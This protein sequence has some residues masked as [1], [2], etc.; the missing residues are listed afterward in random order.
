MDQQMALTW[1]LLFM[2]LLAL[3]WKPGAT[4][5][6]DTIPLQTLS[7]YNDYS[8]H[9]ICS[10]ADLEDAQDLINMTLYRKLG[11][12]YP[13]SCSLS[14]DL[15]WSECPSAH[16]C[17]PRRCVIA[18]TGFSITDEDYYSFQP[19]QDVG[20]Q[21][22][23]PLAQHVQPPPPKDI[24]ISPSGD[25]FLL[26]WNWTLGDAQV[27]WLSQEDVEFE[28]AYKRLQDTWEDALRLNTSDLWV[29]LASKLFLPSNIYVARVRTQLSPG[30]SWSGRPSRWSPEVQWNAQP[31]DKAQPQNLQ[32]FFDGIQSLSCSW[33]VWNQVVGSVSFGLFY[34]PSPAAPEK[35]CSP[36]VKEL[37]G[38]FCTRYYC[39]L[40]VPNPRAHSQYTVSVKLRKQG[41][42]IKSS[43][44]IQMHPPSLKVTKNGDSYNLRWETKKLLYSHIQHKFQV[45]YKK[46]LDSWEDSKTEILD[47]AHSMSLPRL[48]P[49]TS[50]SARVRVKPLPEY[51][52]IWSEW[53][54]E[55]T[56]TTNW[57][58]PTWGIVLI[59][60][61]LILILILALRFGCAYGCRLYRK[62]KEKIPNPSKSLLFQDGGKG[63]WSPSSTAAFATKNLTPR[64]PQRNFF[65]E[66]QGMSYSH[67]VDNEVSPLTIEVPKIV[68]DLPSGPDPT[69]VTSSEP[70]EQLSDGQRDPQTHFGKPESQKPNFD[71]N[72]P[73]LGPPKTHSLTNL[74]GQLVPPE[75]S[76]SLKP[77]L[78]HSLEYLCLPP[79]GQVQL[80]PLSQAMSK[81][82]AMDAERESSLKTTE[83]PSVEQRDSPSLD[84]RVE[85]QEPKD[86]AVTLSLNSG[87][88]ED[89]VVASG[90][91]TP[92]DLVLT[93]PTGPPSTSLG[94]SLGLPS[95]Q[96]PSL[97]LTLPGVPPGSPALPAPELDDYVELPPSISQPPKIPLG[98]PVPPV[99]S[100]TAVNPGE[101]REEVAPTSPHHEGLLVLQQVGDYCFLPGLAPGSLSPHSKPPSP[102]L[103]LEMVDLDQ[104]LSV[105]KPSCQPMPQVPAIQFF[106]SLKHQDYLSLPPWDSSQPGKVC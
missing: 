64:G 6:Q 97:C 51:Y 55:C 5:A 43:D 93:L 3:C 59:L 9:I 53:S 2:A 60:I 80:V 1:S 36:V 7:C 73:Y 89:P 74:Q 13:V 8:S 30:S 42:F 14:D 95:A 35:E 79:G 87:G 94:P 82:Q 69:P 41:K 28:V 76:G 33:E 58:M 44:H 106:K 98:N 70:T 81:G 101:H 72:G 77:E 31:G 96:G 61:V 21:L 46:K 54:E 49:S 84:L 68:Q 67:T 63:L 25:H 38:S 62:W 103:C 78:P 48:V 27:P 19:D 91:V 39:N 50:Y 18:Y 22:V 37:Q 47:H 102:G 52:G 105:K 90:Y 26:K 12:D 83:S 65:T 45:Q 86:N 11:K 15:V 17:V 10:W 34:R 100:S 66:L 56:W 24:N 85:E 99:P 20:I 29:S 75:I 104:D 32:C 92:A 16:R 88:T 40:T 57:V 71:F 23:V 4:E